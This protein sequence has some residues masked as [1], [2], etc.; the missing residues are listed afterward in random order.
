MCF[1]KLVKPNCRIRLIDVKASRGTNR[2]LTISSSK[3]INQTLVSDAIIERT[4]HP[5]CCF[6]AP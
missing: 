6:L 3:T 4:Q 5:L 2:I 1:N